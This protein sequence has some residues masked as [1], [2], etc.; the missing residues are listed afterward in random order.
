M[1]R[2]MY[3]LYI[4]RGYSSQSRGDNDIACLA[5]C[6]DLPVRNITD[7]GVGSDSRPDK[8]SQTEEVRDPSEN[9]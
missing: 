6:T 7:M 8:A 4:S 9:N 5:Q 1:D 2:A 3:A